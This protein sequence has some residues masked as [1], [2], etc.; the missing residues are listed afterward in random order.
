MENIR[1]WTAVNEFHNAVDLLRTPACQDESDYGE[2]DLRLFALDI[3]DSYIKNDSDMQINISASQRNKIQR[4]LKNTSGPI[5]RGIFD[6]AQKEVYAMM[7]RHSY[8][9]FLV[10]NKSNASKVSN[11][12]KR[13]TAITPDGIV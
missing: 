6:S 5:K 8:P 12:T 3:V 10:S 7:S 2:N 11:S 13:S 4:D 9:R 1:F